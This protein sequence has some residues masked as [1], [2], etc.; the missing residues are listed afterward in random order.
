[1]KKLLVLALLLCSTVAQAQT[2][3]NSS[4]PSMRQC[5]FSGAGGTLCVDPSLAAAVL[6]A[7]PLNGVAG[8][9]TFKLK[10]QGYSTVGCNIN[11]TYG[12]ATSVTLTPSISRDNGSSYG[13]MT[14]NNS[15]GTLGANAAYTDTYTGTSSVNWPVSYDVRT[16]DWL[17]IVVSGGGS[18]TSSDVVT[19]SC[20]AAVGQ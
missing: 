16:M 1:M 10:V 6:T 7:S 4:A 3:F 5:K 13:P 15:N 18:P 2:W 20:I 19:V 12:A 8:V 9:R 11:Y 14:T 17:Q